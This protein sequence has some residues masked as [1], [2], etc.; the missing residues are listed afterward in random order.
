MNVILKDPVLNAQH[1]LSAFLALQ[2]LP[3]PPKQELFCSLL[4]LLCVTSVSSFLRHTHFFFHPLRECVNLSHCG[5]PTATAGRRNSGALAADGSVLLFS[6][7]F[8]FIP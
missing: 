8:F 7:F 4:T 2:C 5:N 1:L 6:F 3:Q